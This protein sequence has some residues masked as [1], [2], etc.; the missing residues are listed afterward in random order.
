MWLGLFNDAC[1]KALLMKLSHVPR[2]GASGLGVVGFA[3]MGIGF[4]CDASQQ[5]GAA[6]AE[7]AI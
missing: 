3:L 7:S 6:E 2:V 4:S 5:G 1:Q